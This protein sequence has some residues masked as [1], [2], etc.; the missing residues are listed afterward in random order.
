MRH[1]NNVRIL[2]RSHEHR[3]AMFANM[4]TSLFQHERVITTKQKGKE[5]KRIAERLITRAKA[6]LNL[7]ENDNAKKLHNKREVMRLIHNE[8]VVK[9]L[10]DDIAPRFVTRPGGYTRMYLL[11]RRQ[12]D[13]AEMAIVE[14]VVKTEKKQEEKKDKEKKSKEKK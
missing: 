9:K 12:G 4:V 2:G 10:F 8:D 1:R 5:L 6:N 13:A 7:T 3:K 11:D 14:L